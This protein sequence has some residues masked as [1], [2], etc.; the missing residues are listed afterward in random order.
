MQRRAFAEH[1]DFWFRVLPHTSSGVRSRGAGLNIL[2]CRVLKAS[3]AHLLDRDSRERCTEIGDMKRK[4]SGQGDTAASLLGGRENL[5]HLQ[6]TLISW[7]R[8]EGKDYPWR[9]TRDPYAILVSEAMLQQTRIAT[10]LERGYFTRWMRVFPDWKTLATA[11]EGAVL[12]EWEG[13][14]YYNRA[15]NLWK[16]AK[17]IESEFSGDFPVD[18]REAQTL[19]G[20]GRYTSGAV[21]SF[22]FGHRAALVD[23]N[24]ERVFARLFAYE[25]E[26]NSTEGSRQIWAWAEEMVPEVNSRF[27]NSALMEIGQRFCLRKNPLCSSCPLAT[28]CIAANRGIAEGL[29]R[30]KKS[31]S[32]TR[33]QEFV[34]ICEKS[35]AIYLCQETGP[36]R[37]G[38][39]RLPE[40]DISAS[41]GEMLFSFDYSITRYR[42]TLSVFRVG[43]A[44]REE[45]TAIEKSGWFPLQDKKSW[46]ALGAPYKKAIE[47]YCRDF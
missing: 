21:L 26:V 29:P 16:A 27:F 34:G 47:I 14:G 19:P 15:R 7:F 32:L 9:R 24:V 17:I 39:W 6:Q 36:R 35:G 5:E 23:G 25:E 11:S 43:N 13:L 22:A 41:T 12:K 1:S 18:P 46:P 45:A 44:K 38:L 10:V 8:K 3:V 37:K 42:V 40:L 30:K 31:S 33:R 28:F 20:V 2:L 4:T